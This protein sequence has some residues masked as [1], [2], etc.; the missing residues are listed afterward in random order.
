MNRKGQILSSSLTLGGKLFL[1]AVIAFVLVVVVG[2]VFSS[3]LDVRPAET[4]ILENKI[5]ECLVHDG[6]IQ[7]NFELKECFVEDQEIY[8]LANL[9]SMDSNFSKSVVS[10]NNA[11]GVLC[12]AGDEKLY[13]DSQRYYVLINHLKVERGILELNIGINKYDKNV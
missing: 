6:V 10:G 2:G 5:V 12:K 4:A 8:V 13:C 7:S 11:L 3:N 1:L 9:S